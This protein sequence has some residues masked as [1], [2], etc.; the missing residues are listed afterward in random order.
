[1][2]S[3]KEQNPFHITEFITENNLKQI[4]KSEINKSIIT[5]VA[6]S[7]LHLKILSIEAY[8]NVCLH[9][10]MLEF[11]TVACI[12]HRKTDGIV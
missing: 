1:M 4:Q 10:A 11:K 3:K 9:R 2:V 6:R 7:L 8:K 12:R 5:P